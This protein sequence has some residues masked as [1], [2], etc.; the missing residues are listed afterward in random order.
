MV[1]GKMEKPVSDE[2]KFDPRKFKDD[3]RDQIHRAVHA[4]CKA[5]MESRSRGGIQCVGHSAPRARR[6]GWSQVESYLIGLPFCS[7]TWELFHRQS[8]AVLAP[9]PGP[10]GRHKLPCRNPDLGAL[11]M[12]AAPFCSSMNWVYH[13]AGQHF[14]HDADRFRSVCHVGLDAMEF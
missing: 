9:A 3:L 14:A 13:S 4:A 11:L 10:N 2:N 5:M 1:H 8:L 6:A 7:I 12:F